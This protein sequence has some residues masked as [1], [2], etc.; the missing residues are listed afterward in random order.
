MGKFYTPTSPLPNFP[1]HL[2]ILQKGILVK[3]VKLA[4]R[5]FPLRLRRIWRLDYVCC[6]RNRMLVKK[7]SMIKNLVCLEEAYIGS[8]L[9]AWEESYANMSI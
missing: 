5:T 8:G 1:I 7:R 6:F 3:Y 9:Y 4:L 2:M